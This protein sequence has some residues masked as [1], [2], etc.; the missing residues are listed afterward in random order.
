MDVKIDKKCVF[1]LKEPSS[2]KEKRFITLDNYYQ[3]GLTNDE[4]AQLANKR[5][6]RLSKGI[7]KYR[8]KCAVLTCNT[9]R[10]KL[11]LREVNSNDRN[12]HAIK[13][14]FGVHKG[15]KVR[16]SQRRK[17]N[18]G[19]HNYKTRQPEPPTM[20]R[21][22]EEMSAREKEGM[23]AREME[24]R[25]N[26]LI[27]QH[28]RPTQTRNQAETKVNKGKNDHGGRPRKKYSEGSASTKLIYF[29]V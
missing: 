4:Y 5:I 21:Q 24:T 17:E 13:Q 6:C 29:T 28:E 9:P 23:N 18:G 12:E 14:K 8:K 2:E 3:L 25:R 19:T 22:N 20:T 11:K 1:C 10:K 7:P 15:E 16:S 26:I 27:Q